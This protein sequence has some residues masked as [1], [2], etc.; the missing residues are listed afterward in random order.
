MESEEDFRNMHPTAISVLN[1]K[2]ASSVI[3]YKKGKKEKVVRYVHKNLKKGGKKK[4]IAGWRRVFFI[5]ITF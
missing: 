2:H 3:F 1:S 5:Y 4:E